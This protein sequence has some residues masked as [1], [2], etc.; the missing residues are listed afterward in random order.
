MPHHKHCNI[1]TCT[2]SINFDSRDIQPFEIVACD[3]FINL[4]LVF[5]DRGAKNEHVST[6]EFIPHYATLARNAE[7]LAA[8]TEQRDSQF[9][10]GSL[11]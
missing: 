7:Q 10:I 3:G 2:E 8:E 4:A 6:E 11:S 9:V 5:I 1:Q